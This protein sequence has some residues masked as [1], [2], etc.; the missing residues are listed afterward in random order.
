MTRETDVSTVSRGLLAVRRE[1][2]A[3]N[4][5]LAELLVL[6]LGPVLPPVD[7]QVEVDPARADPLDPLD[8]KPLSG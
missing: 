3:L 5:L 2:V 6:L 1:Q 7:G 8:H 4:E